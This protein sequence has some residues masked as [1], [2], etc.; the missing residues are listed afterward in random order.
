M[1]QNASFYDKNSQNFDHR[2]THFNII[3]VMYDKASQIVLNDES[4][5]ASHIK[6]GKMR[7]LSLQLLL[8]NT[9]MEVLA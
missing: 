9:V 3:N 8:F 1:G 4:L 5:K 2:R 6:L 7:N